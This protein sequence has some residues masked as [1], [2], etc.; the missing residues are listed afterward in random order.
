MLQLSSVMPDTS[1]RVRRLS[2]A[3]LFAG[4][5]FGTGPHQSRSID[6]LRPP[7][8]PPVAHAS[9]AISGRGVAQLVPGRRP[10]AP[11][12]PELHARGNGKHT[13]VDRL[14][15]AFI[16]SKQ[17]ATDC[18]QYGRWPEAVVRTRMHPMHATLDRSDVWLMLELP[19]ACVQAPTVLLPPRPR[20]CMYTAL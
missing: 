16:R 19:R 2:K 12:N 11:P 18:Q 9:V 6:L 10:V 17:L 3:P 1:G 15:T 13:Q 7:T 20:R 5:E 4:K 8:E 14:A